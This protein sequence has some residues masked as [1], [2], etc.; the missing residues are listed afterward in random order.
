MN[1][2]PDLTP[3]MIC[4][5]AVIYL[6]QE[7]PQATN[8]NSACDVKIIGNYGSDFDTSEFEAI[9]CDE[10]VSKLISSKRLTFARYNNAL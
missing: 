4:E 5:K 7:S 3:C 6:W 2:R 10:C 1:K 8:L 9:I